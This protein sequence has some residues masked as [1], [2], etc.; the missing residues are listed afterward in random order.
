MP[1]QIELPHKCAFISVPRLWQL[2]P[3][4]VQRSRRV[5]VLVLWPPQ[6]FPE[7]GFPNAQEGLPG[8]GS[9]SQSQAREQ[10][11]STEVTAWHPVS[12]GCPSSCLAETSTQSVPFTAAATVP[13]CPLCPA[14]LGM[15]QSLLQSKPRRKV[16]AWPFGCGLWS[17]EGGGCWCIFPQNQW[18]GW[19]SCKYHSWVP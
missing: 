17:V 9:L 11:A 18:T 10:A 16:S 6:A 1:C 8:Q 13:V 14:V 7:A 4:S 2:S 12:L 5:C 19:S 15:S 3:L